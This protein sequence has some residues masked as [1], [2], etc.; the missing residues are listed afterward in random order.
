MK[1]ANQQDMV[2]D[3]EKYRDKIRAIKVA[4]IELE[5]ALSMDTHHRMRHNERA[6]MGE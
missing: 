1:D 6:G 5:A 2:R 3:L 4:I